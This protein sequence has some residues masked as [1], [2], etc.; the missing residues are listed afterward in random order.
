MKKEKEQL[1]DIEQRVSDKIAELVN[2]VCEGIT[3]V[4]TGKTTAALDNTVMRSGELMSNLFYSRD[5]WG[6]IGSRISYM[7]PQKEF[8]EGV[9]V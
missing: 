2:E 6:F 1:N 5:R 9:V 3:I 7:K 8:V 4:C